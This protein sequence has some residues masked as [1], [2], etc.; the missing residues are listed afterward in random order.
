MSAAVLAPRPTSASSA[1]H[2]PGTRHPL[3]TSSSLL[4]PSQ[5][6][7]APGRPSFGRRHL[8]R[9]TASPP[10][11]TLLATAS[12]LRPPKFRS[13]PPCCGA[14]WLQEPCQA[15]HPAR[16]PLASASRALRGRGA[17]RSCLEPS[18]VEAARH[19][20]T[21][22]H[23][24]QRPSLPAP[25]S[26]EPSDAF[27]LRRF[28]ALHPLDPSLG[29]C[30]AARSHARP[31]Q[32]FQRSRTSWTGPA[33]AESPVPSSPSPAASPVPSL[34][35]HDA[36]AQAATPPLVRCVQSKAAPGSGSRGRWMKPREGPVLWQACH[37]ASASPACPAPASGAASARPRGRRRSRPRPPRPPGA[38][39]PSPPSRWAAPAPR[40]RRRPPHPQH[41]MQ[42]GGH[43]HAVASR[44]CQT[45]PCAMLGPEWMT[46][47]LGEAV[48]VQP[49][50]TAPTPRPSSTTAPRGCRGNA[51]AASRRKPPRAALGRR[52][53]R[54]EGARGARASAIISQ[55]TS[56]G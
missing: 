38:S 32:V 31:G 1:R 24:G 50:R 41:G 29:Q 8:R 45:P 17:V 5:D 26:Q 43:E 23:Q 12:P 47:S 27:A 52:A 53:L 22:M 34:A 54:Q 15:A 28:E 42:F 35:S 25:A 39:P 3:G 37:P 19:G 16:R 44:P 21:A 9:G 14:S 48:E 46:R 7:Q 55:T 30:Q 20:Q 11:K 51:A 4:G 56:R 36:W 6:A 40:R 49:A 13:A 10:P 18:L 33:V 2:R